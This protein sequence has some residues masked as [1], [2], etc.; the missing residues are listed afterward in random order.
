[1]NKMPGRSFAFG[2]FATSLSTESLTS[3]L[4]EPAATDQMATSFATLAKA[5]AII[6]VPSPKSKVIPDPVC[7]SVL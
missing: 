7:I 1:M 2:W 5:A 3:W 4:V 6:P